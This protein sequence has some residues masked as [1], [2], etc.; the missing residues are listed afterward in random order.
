MNVN[1][2]VSEYIVLHNVIPTYPQ[3]IRNKVD[4]I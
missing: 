1:Q 2:W 4:R 3:E